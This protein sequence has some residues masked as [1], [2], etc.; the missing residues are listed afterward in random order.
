MKTTI[1]LKRAG[2]S[3]SE[4]TAS[5]VTNAMEF[6]AAQNMVQCYVEKQVSCRAT[7]AQFNAAVDAMR[8]AGL[9]THADVVESLWAEIARARG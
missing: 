5:G 8:Q 7:A 1:L 6:R 4:I 9:G 2:Y 3:D